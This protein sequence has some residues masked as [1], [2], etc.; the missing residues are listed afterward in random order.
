MQPLNPR[1]LLVSVLL[2]PALNAMLQ[3]CSESFQDFCMNAG[4]KS[5]CLH[6]KCFCPL[7]HLSILSLV[8]KWDLE[9]VFLEDKGYYPNVVHRLVI[10]VFL[11]LKPSVS[12]S[13]TYLPTRV[14]V[15]FCY[16]FLLAFSCASSH[17]SNTKLPLVKL[18]SDNTYCSATSPFCCVSRSFF[19]R[20]GLLL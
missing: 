14:H 7:S 12:P 19:C 18:F 10:E 15:Y 6:S 13:F 1:N 8:L 16:L 2:F 9:V 17:C 5:S 20:S 11:F 3:A 4:I